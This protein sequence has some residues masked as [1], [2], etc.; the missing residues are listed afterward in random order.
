MRSKVGRPVGVYGLTKLVSPC[1]MLS[2]NDRRQADIDIISCHS[3]ITI[4]HSRVPSVSRLGVWIQQYQVLSLVYRFWEPSPK[5]LEEGE[6][7]N[8][9]DTSPSKP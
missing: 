2:W 4:I 1:L 6:A 5:K 9:H 3:V 8:V 7:N